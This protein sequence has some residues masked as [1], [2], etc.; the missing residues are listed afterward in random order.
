MFASDSLST[1]IHK[2]NHQSD[3]HS[4]HLCRLGA[5]KEYKENLES[6]HLKK[7]IFTLNSVDFNLFVQ[8]SVK[9]TRSNAIINIQ[10]RFLVHLYTFVNKSCTF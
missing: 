3:T 5:I 7:K 6:T 1:H 10:F 2:A 9:C 4:C 8:C